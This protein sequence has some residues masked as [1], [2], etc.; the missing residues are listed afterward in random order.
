MSVGEFKLVSNNFFQIFLIMEENLYYKTNE[1]KWL[2]FISYV[3]NVYVFQGL[4]FHTQRIIDGDTGHS[5]YDVR[6]LI[7][8]HIEYLD[9]NISLI[10]GVT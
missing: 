1:T 10:I 7:L 9:N 5:R 8:L 3:C 2:L 4:R 6:R